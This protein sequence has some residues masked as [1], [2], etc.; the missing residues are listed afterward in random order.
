[1]TGKIQQIIDDIRGKTETLHRQLQEERAT[2]ARLQNEI[3]ELKTIIEKKE[4][5]ES[6]LFSDI[7]K[8]KMELE[9]TRNQ[10]QDSSDFSVRNRDEEIDELVKEIEYCISQLKNK[11]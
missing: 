9:T 7:E 11:A 2:S 1:M 8:L 6:L 10:V 3:T 5:H 4:Q